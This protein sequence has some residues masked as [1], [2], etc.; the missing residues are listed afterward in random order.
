MANGPDR[1]PGRNQPDPENIRQ[2]SFQ[3]GTDG[4]SSPPTEIPTY[5]DM[6]YADGEGPF[7]DVDGRKLSAGLSGMPQANAGTAPALFNDPRTPPGQPG[8]SNTP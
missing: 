2:R 3:G 5:G 8:G 6:K 7:A 1:V 4:L